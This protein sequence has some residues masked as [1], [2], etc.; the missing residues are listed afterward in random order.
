[1]TDIRDCFLRELDQED[2]GMKGHINNYTL[3]L[4]TID[5]VLLDTIEG[6]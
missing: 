5:P 2:T 4:S 3:I 1:M 6:N